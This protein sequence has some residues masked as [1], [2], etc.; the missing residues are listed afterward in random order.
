MGVTIGDG[1]II[2]GGSVVTKDVPPYAIAVGNPA[3]VIKYRFSEEIIE[4]LLSLAWWRYA[5]WELNKFGINFFDIEITIEQIRKRVDSGDL[6][7]YVPEKVK[8]AELLKIYSS[9]Y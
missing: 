7:C 8:I 5:P 3:K 9:Y 6:Q 1:V 4:Q 2:G